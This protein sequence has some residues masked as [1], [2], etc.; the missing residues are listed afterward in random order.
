[1]KSYPGDFLSDPP[2]TD[3]GL[4]ENQ[5]FWKS[6]LETGVRPVLRLV[7]Q[8]ELPRPAFEERLMKLGHLQTPPPAQARVL[9][10]WYSGALN[11]WGV[12]LQRNGRW[13]EATPCFSLALELNPDN[14]PA[15]VNLQCNSNLLA[16][17]KMTVVRTQVFPE[18]LGRYRSLN[19]VLTE[20]GPFDEP[21]YCYRLG[22]GFAEGK[23]RRQ[24]G[25]QFDRVKALVPSDFSVRLTLGN[26]FN[27]CSRPELALG[28]VAEMQADPELR[29][30]GL[31]NEVEVALLEARAYLTATNQAT[32]QGIIYALLATHPG[33][34]ALLAR[35]VTTFADYQCYS[36]AI[37]LTDHQ[38]Q[39]TPDDPAALANKGILCVLTGDS[40]NAI[41]T[42]TRSLSLTNTY[43][44]RLNRAIA[45]L[46]TGRLDAAEADYQA[47]LQQ[48]PTAYRASAMLGE[49]ALQKKETNTAIRYYEHYL[50]KVEPDTE[51]A[52][53]VAARLKSLQPGR[54]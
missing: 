43:V 2:L 21:S 15:L 40:S 18:Q 51:D 8:P 25:Q 31:T 3:A 45:Y 33:D 48:F 17:Q 29:P 30:L 11:R 14:L 41:P 53:V 9:A 49:V 1:M 38:L 50:S 22:M 46:R 20:N 32:A 24:A 7:S 13:S 27:T 23:M 44:A 4:A 6:A 52:K 35:A 10:R 39:L 47:L 37:R 12:T 16:H 36:D 42:L 54:H 26:L 19:Q 34:S 5:A 28:I